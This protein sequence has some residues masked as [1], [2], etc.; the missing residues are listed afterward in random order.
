MRT[1][2]KIA[3]ALLS[4]F[5]GVDEGAVGDLLEEFQSGKSS[6]WYWRQAAG[7]VCAAVG[8]EFRV[9][10]AA[11]V[12]CLLVGVLVPWAVPITVVR[13]TI[14]AAYRSYTRWY[15]DQGGLPP[16]TSATFNWVLNFSIRIA[17]NAFG[18][19][20]A[21]RSYRGHQPL[22]A[23]MFAVMVA[24]QQIALIVSFSIVLDPTTI[25]ARYAFEPIPP[26]VAM[27]LMM[28]PSVAALVGGMLGARRQATRAV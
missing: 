22:M 26:S 14:D 10:P 24:C 3:S 9:H 7:V 23:L 28:V 5:S 25:P 27:P 11:I 12:L 8:R 18:G 4:Y 20:V 6:A 21:V 13:P 15:F 19:F 16:P 2:P 1:P 17:A